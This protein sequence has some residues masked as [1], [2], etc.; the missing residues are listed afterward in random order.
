MTEQELDQLI[1]KLLI[2]ALKSDL[3]EQ[4]EPQPEFIPSESYRKQMVAMEHDP[5]GWMKRKTKPLWKTIIQRIAIVLLAFLVGFGSIMAVV[6][7]ARASV[8][9]WVTEWYED[10]VVYRFHGERRTDELPQY[11]ITAL[12]DGYTETERIEF[13]ALDGEVT[14]QNDVGDVIWFGYSSIQQGGAA[15]FDTKTSDVFDIS[16]NHNSG[17]FFQTKIAGNFNTIV[18]IDPEQNILFDIS[19]DFGRSELLE[20]AESVY[21]NKKNLNFSKIM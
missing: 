16:V 6:P 7:T 10:H 21:P 13:S 3:E 12:P 19:G 14:Y 4:T 15:G 9:R 2:D 20:M 11:E 1:K 5:I 18:W 8:I 17:Q